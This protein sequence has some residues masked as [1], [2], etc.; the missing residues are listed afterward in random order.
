MN[1]FVDVKFKFSYTQMH[2]V[3]SIS[4]A[5]FCQTWQ[6][7]GRSEFST[8][9][10]VGA[11]ADISFAEGRKKSEKLIILQSVAALIHLKWMYLGA[12]FVQFSS[13]PELSPHHVQE[14]RT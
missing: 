6:R 8:A 4:P 13:L 5:S 14:L 7:E 2:P 9:H 3:C 11:W 10:Q 1:S 12:S